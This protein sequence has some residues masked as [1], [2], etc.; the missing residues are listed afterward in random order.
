M[1]KRLVIL[2]MLLVS[3]WALI[4][5]SQKAL[6]FHQKHLNL[7]VLKMNEGLTGLER[8]EGE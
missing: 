4:V 3:F 6:G 8:H 1:E 5:V 7:C 2:S